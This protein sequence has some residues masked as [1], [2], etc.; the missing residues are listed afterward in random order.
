ME[1]EITEDV[2]TTNSLNDLIQKEIEK[3]K[4]NRKI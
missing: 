1:R 4:K 3:E 2:D